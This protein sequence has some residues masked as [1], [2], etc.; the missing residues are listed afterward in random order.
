MCGYVDGPNVW[1]LIV[2]RCIRNAREEA[3][4]LLWGYSI[5]IGYFAKASLEDQCANGD[6]AMG[7]SVH[8]G[9]LLEWCCK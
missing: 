4:Q 5:A 6:D 7:L 9:C 8:Q 3:D 1:P 2:C